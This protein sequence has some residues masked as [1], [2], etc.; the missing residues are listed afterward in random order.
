METNYCLK[1]NEEAITEIDNLEYV[2]ED[3]NEGI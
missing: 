2:D 1:E 3:E